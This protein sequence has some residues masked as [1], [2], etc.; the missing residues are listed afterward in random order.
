MDL[1][2]NQQDLSHVQGTTAENSQI[3]RCSHQNLKLS[4]E[5]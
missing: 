1:G 5:K 2:M 4:T 3:L